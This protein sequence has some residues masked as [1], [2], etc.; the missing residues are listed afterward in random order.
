[1][2]GMGDVI[3]IARLALGLTQA[4]LADLVGVSQPALARYEHDLREPEP[5]IMSRLSSALG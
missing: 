1:M 2:T 5:E 3:S 4:Q